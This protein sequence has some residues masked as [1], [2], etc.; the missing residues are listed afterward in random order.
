LGTLDLLDVLKD[1]DYLSEFTSEFTSVTSRE[2]VDRDTLRRRILL[3]LFALGTNICIKAIVALVSTA[4]PRPQCATYVFV[5]SPAAICAAP[6][7]SWYQRHLAGSRPC[8]AGYR[9]RVRVGFRVGF[10][11]VQLLGVE[12]DDRNTTSTIQVRTH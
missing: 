2:V 6:S 8:L 10:K 11:E 7:P 9:H 3:C 4:N 5:S 1:S 12:P